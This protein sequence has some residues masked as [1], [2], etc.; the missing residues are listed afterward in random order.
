MQKP[1]KENVIP[2]STF[3]DNLRIAR[4][5]AGYTQQELADLLKIDKQ[6]YASYET[7]NV[8]PRFETLINISLHLGIRIDELLGIKFANADVLTE[9]VLKRSLRYLNATVK[10]D[11]I[12]VRFGKTNSEV[13]TDLAINAKAFSDIFSRIMRKNYTIAMKEVVSRT[14]REVMAYVLKKAVENSID[15]P[16]FPQQEKPTQKRKL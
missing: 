4:E 2:L 5:Q 8:Q 14:S 7:R 6:T 12:I 15:K 1:K 11:I 9:E 16:F 3:A 10:K 13:D